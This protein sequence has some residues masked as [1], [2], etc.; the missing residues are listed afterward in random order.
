VNFLNNENAKIKQAFDNYIGT[1]KKINQRNI[2][3]FN[4]WLEVT[5][6]KREREKLY[7]FPKVITALLFLILIFSIPAVINLNQKHID[8]S[9]P[10]GKVQKEVSIERVPIEQ[11]YKKIS[12]IESNFRLFMPKEKAKQVFG[13]GISYT[14]SESDMEV[15]EYHFLG[16]NHKMEQVQLSKDSFLSGEIGVHFTIIWNEN[17]ATSAYIHFLNKEDELYNITYKPNGMVYKGGQFIRNSLYPLD[18]STLLV[19]SIANSL[20]EEPTAIDESKLSKIKKL[21]IESTNSDNF[22]E[23]LSKDFQY[24]KDM[25]NLETLH[26]KGI[27]VPIDT[28]IEINTLRTLIIEGTTIS[29][30]NV[31]ILAKM[32]SLEKIIIEKDKLK[33]WEELEASGITVIDN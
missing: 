9:K 15:T 14:D 29:S 27:A 7:I 30:G 6:G 17:K 4:K 5:K 8:H 11:V 13:E 1:S 2:D 23:L 24:I 12:E 10:L 16:H 19:K 28:I 3:R 32:E 26:L 31:S 20:G 25:P 21:V 18:G 22:E 33:G